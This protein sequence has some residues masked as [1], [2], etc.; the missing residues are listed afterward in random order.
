ME[1]YSLHMEG[2][3]YVAKMFIAP[4]QSIDSVNSVSE[5]SW[6]FSQSRKA[7]LKFVCIHKIP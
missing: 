7:I 2:K 6:H 5:V 4:R 1:K 3:N